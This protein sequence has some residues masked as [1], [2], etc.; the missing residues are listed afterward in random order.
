[1]KAI[2]HLRIINETVADWVEP[3]SKELNEHNTGWTQFVL[4]GP[5]I[6]ICFW[7]DCVSRLAQLESAK[8]ERLSSPSKL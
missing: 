6:E 3:I 4:Y 2:N 5:I 1:M 7:M 8:I